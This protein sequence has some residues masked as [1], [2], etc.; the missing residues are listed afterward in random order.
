MRHLLAVGIAAAVLVST[1]RADETQAPAEARS[2]YD[3]AEIAREEGRL[4]EAVEHY[5]RA[6]SLHPLYWQAHAGLLAALRGAGEPSRTSDLYD[7]LVA[8]HPDSVELK[9]FQAAAREPEEAARMLDELAS[10]HADNLRV[11]IELARAQLRMGDA[12]NAE[13]SAKKALAIDDASMAARILLGDAYLAGDKLTSARKEY[14]AVLDQASDNVPARLK[15][16]LALH[17]SNKTDEALA[18][19][20]RM[21]SE[22]NLPR[23]VAAHWLIGSILIEKGAHADALKSLDAILSVDKNDHDALIVKGQVLLALEKPV[24]AAKVFEEAVKAYP[25][26]GTALFCLGWAQEKSAESPEIKDAQR[27]ERLE[28]AAAAYEKCT[29]LDPSVRPRDS[30]GFVYLLGDLHREAI[31]QFRRAMDIDPRF[32]SAHNNLGLAS[33]MADNR[34][35]AKKRYDH[36]L[37]KI[38][39]Q[40]V[41]A[42]VMLALDHWLDGSTNKAIKLLKQALKAAPDDDLAWTFLGDVYYDTKKYAQ[43]IDA[44]EKAV[45]IDDKNFFA[46]YHMGIAYDEDRKKDEEADQCYRKALECKAD[47]PPELALRLA[48]VNEKENLDRLEEALRFYQLYIDLGGDVSSPG[49]DWIPNRMEEIQKEL[50]KKKK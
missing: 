1:L 25:K 23:L 2:E 14:Q 36:V 26:S 28:A 16:A 4:E 43:A 8:D 5:K 11:W 29:N 32:A 21:V 46:W 7:S 27:K 22:D 40:N 49:T 9:A 48:E 41:R 10:A 13:K 35:E 31:T 30:L 6:I 19:L 18:L 50:A 37:K 3:K 20:R 15:L 44:Y 24:E 38:D 42:M 47:P 12:R 34:S 33:D 39:R 45:E 17:R